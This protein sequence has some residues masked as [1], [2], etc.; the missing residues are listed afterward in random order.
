MLLERVKSSNTCPGNPDNDFVEMIVKE[1][2]QFLGTS[3]E[4]VAT[5]DT[6]SVAKT[7]RVIVRC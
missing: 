3:G 6:S 7:A 2:G 4:V 5:L 1:G